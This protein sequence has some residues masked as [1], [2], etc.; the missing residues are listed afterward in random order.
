VRKANWI[1]AGTRRHKNAPDVKFCGKSHDKYAI[2]AGTAGTQP[3]HCAG[4]TKR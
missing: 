3:A 4:T 1:W 2:L